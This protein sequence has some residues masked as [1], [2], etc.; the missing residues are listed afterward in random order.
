MLANNEISQ[1]AAQA[2]AWHVTD[3]LSWQELLVKNR[4]ERMDG[5]FVR[6]FHP[7]HVRLAQQVVVAATERADVRAKSQRQYQ[8]ATTESYEGDY[9]SGNE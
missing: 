2:A 8:S 9:D 1:P 4:V 7:D 3:G 6:Y 5:S